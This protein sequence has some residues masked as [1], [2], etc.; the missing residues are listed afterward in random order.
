VGD[1]PILIYPRDGNLLS[2]RPAFAWFSSGPG[3]KY[4]IKLFQDT[5]TTCKESG[6]LLWMRIVQDTTSVFPFDEPELTP[7]QKYWLEVS[8]EERY[9]PEDL[10]CFTV[11][12]CEERTSVGDSQK[13]IR[14]EYGSD[15]PQE[16][17][18]A[19]LYAA[20]LIREELFSDALFVIQ[21][22]LAQQPENM[23][24]RFMRDSVY[25]AFD[26]PAVISSKSK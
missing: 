7:G 3:K 4:R 1:P 6:D 18:A 10:A 25:T 13:E 14:K 5:G 21:A 9:D 12:S 8:R 15:D 16:V 26:L 11:T 23:S 24:L 22:A 19:A 20:T 17:A 2:L